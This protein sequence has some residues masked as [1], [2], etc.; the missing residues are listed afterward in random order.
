MRS[1]TGR[2][3][4]SRHATGR[5][6]SAEERG[7]VEVFV[8]AATTVAVAQLGWVRVPSCRW[9]WSPVDPS[10]GGEVPGEALIG[11]KRIHDAGHIG[12]G[13]CR[14]HAPP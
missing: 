5:R 8:D 9:T 14:K 11:V 2:Q 3:P 1:A 6:L 4:G 13:G 12:H 7:L 10:V